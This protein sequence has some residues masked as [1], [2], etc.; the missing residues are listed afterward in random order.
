M[1]TDPAIHAGAMVS[2]TW[3]ERNA[4]QLRAIERPTKARTASVT[5]PWIAQS[6]RRAIKSSRT[7]RRPTARASTRARESVD[8][9]TCRPN[10]RGGTRSRSE[11][12]TSELQSR[13]HLVCR[14]LLEKKKQFVDIDA[15]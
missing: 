4:D 8:R 3:S 1:T 10:P 6:Q 13:L 12:H 14:L 11:E 5:R 15:V 9:S 2:V 7:C